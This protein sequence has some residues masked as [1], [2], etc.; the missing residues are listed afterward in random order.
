MNLTR[1]QA[2]AEFR[3]MWRWIAQK[4]LMCE[5]KVEKKEYFIENDLKFVNSYCYLCE[6]SCS[7]KKHIFKFESGC[8]FCPIIRAKERIICNCCNGLYYLW[9]KE[10]D[11]KKCAKLAKQISELPESEV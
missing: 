5:R 3:K 10:T 4:T 8:A 2:V 1:E 11:Y 6:Y 9:E 7:Q